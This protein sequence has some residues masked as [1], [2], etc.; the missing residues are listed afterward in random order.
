MQKT[1]FTTLIILL[2]SVNLASQDTFTLKSKTLGGNSTNLEEFNGFGCTGQNVSPELN[3]INAPEGTKSFAITMYDSDAPTG[4]GWWHW[5]V[6][7]IPNN[8]KSVC[9]NAGNIEEGLMPQNVIQSVTN[10]GVAGYG[11]PC[12]PENHGIHT[13]EISVHA[14][15]VDKLGLDENTNPAIVGYYIWNNTIAKASIITHYERKK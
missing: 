8:I 9:E 14:L 13:Y 6:F 10:Y 15:K 12:P 1:I 4:S 3:W 11:G 5:V 7:D 2:F